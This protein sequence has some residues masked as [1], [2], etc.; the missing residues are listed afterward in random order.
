MPDDGSK[1]HMVERRGALRAAR[2]VTGIAITDDRRQER[3]WRDGSAM[4]STRGTPTMSVLVVGD[5]EHCLGQ[6]RA[7]RPSWKVSAAAGVLVWQ[8]SGSLSSRSTHWSSTSR[9]HVGSDLGGG[10][11]CNGPSAATPVFAAL[12]LSAGASSHR[13]GT[14]QAFAFGRLSSPPVSFSAAR[15]VFPRSV[16]PTQGLSP[17]ATGLPSWRSR[18]CRF[19]DTPRP[20]CRRSVRP[21]SADR[22]GQLHCGW[23]GE[24][25]SCVSAGTVPMLAIL[26]IPVGFGSVLAIP[27]NRAA[28][29]TV[30]AEQA[31]AAAC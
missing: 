9:C 17:L 2:P 28:V 5:P 16:P 29:G 12:R 31:G 27:A 22:L 20:A 19:R 14:R 13:I 1:A 11:T 6:W 24:P 21:A 4:G 15:T 8:C 10:P 3:R 25:V 7:T 18:G 23:P 26:A 30:P